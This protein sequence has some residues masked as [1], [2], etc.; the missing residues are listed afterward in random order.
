MGQLKDE[1]DGVQNEFGPL[2]SWYMEVEQELSDL[3]AAR[4]REEEKRKPPKQLRAMTM[5]Q[6]RRK[7][8]V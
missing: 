7:L 8:G 1:S 2:T 6:L 5:A 4:E 3:V